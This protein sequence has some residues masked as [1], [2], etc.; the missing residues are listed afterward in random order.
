MSKSIVVCV[1]RLSTSA[2]VIACSSEPA[3]LALVLDTVIV[4][5]STRPSNRSTTGRRRRAERRPPRF[6]PRVKRKCDV[7]IVRTSSQGTGDHIRREFRP[8]V[9][10]ARPKLFSQAYPSCHANSTPNSISISHAALPEAHT[11]GIRILGR[12]RRAVVQVRGE[13]GGKPVA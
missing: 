5:K 6:E 12:G 1:A 10:G 8:L 2:V 7:N 4:D 9:L 11:A 3:P 13:R